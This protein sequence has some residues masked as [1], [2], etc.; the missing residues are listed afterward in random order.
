MFSNFSM[1]P[2]EAYGRKFMTTEH[3]FQALKFKETNEEFFAKVSDAP[4][5]EEA[6]NIAR[7]N[8][9]GFRP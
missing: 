6:K 4:T 7:S 9:D 3:L 1:H 8:Q 5:P 2:V